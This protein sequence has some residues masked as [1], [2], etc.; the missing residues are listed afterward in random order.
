MSGHRLGPEVAP[1]VLPLVVLLGEDHPDQ[2][3]EEARLGKMPTTAVRRLISLLS[4]SWRV[5]AADLAAVR[6]GEREV[7]E[8]VGLGVGQ[9]LGD[10]REARPDAVD[11][12]VD[13]SRGRALVGLL[14]DRA[15]GRRDHAPGRRGT[16]SW[17]LRV[18]G[19]GSAASRAQEL[20]ADG[21]DEA[22]V[23]V[24]S[25]ASG[26]PGSRSRSCAASRT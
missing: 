20:L 13:W 5:G 24:G 17:A 8:Q 22:A 18:S 15:D 23:V 12:P 1:A 16:R 10:R 4:R 21:L 25:C 26:G 7:R 6:L 11:D 2:A 9:Q 3:D 19:P 14:E